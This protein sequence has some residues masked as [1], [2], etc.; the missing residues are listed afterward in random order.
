VCKA[1]SQKD[2]VYNMWHLPLV[3]DLFVVT[4]GAI[5]CYNMNDTVNNVGLLVED[6][7]FIILKVVMSTCHKGV[8]EVLVFSDH[9]RHLKRFEFELMPDRVAR[10]KKIS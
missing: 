3:G 9:R 7:I 2:T 1:L 8:V 4:S 6:D 10:I 5:S